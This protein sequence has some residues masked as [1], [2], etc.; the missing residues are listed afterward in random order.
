M[1]PGIIWLQSLNLTQFSLI[2][3]AA[4]LDLT[5]RFKTFKLVYYTLHIGTSDSGEYSAAHA[6]TRHG[7]RERKGRDA[8]SGSSTSGCIRMVGSCF[9]CLHNVKPR[10]LLVCSPSVTLTAQLA[11]CTVHVV[12]VCFV[13]SSELY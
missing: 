7:F 3:F 4:L 5:K 12:F 11:M 10:P 1:S 13:Y 9:Y 2:L 6:G 8:C